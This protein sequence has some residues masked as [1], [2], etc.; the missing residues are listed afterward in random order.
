MCVLDVIFNTLLIF[1]T[2]TVHWGGAEV[3]FPGAGMGVPEP[4]W[5]R[6]WQS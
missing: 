2:R 3:V 4:R 6:R 5:E 1:P